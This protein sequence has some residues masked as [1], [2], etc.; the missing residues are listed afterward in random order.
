ML[1]Q[2]EGQLWREIHNGQVPRYGAWAILG[3]IVVL[4]I[5]FAVFGRVKIG[6][7]RAGIT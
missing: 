7:G 2:Y 6:D 5:F 3:M 1:I 4:A